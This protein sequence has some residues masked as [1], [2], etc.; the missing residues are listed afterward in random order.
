MLYIYGFFE[1]EAMSQASNM[2]LECKGSLVYLGTGLNVN[3]SLSYELVFIMLRLGSKDD[4][5]WYVMALPIDI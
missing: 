1:T 5:S 3:P 2:I 4:C